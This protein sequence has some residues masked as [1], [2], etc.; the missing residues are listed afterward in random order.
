MA[1]QHFN[2][3]AS[4]GDDLHGVMA[5]HQLPK[6]ISDKIE[7]IGRLANQGF[8][9]AC[10]VVANDSFKCLPYEVTAGTLW[11][12][13]DMFKQIETLSNEI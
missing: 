8:S 10:A 9:I 2:E 3:S 1:T 13:E 7:A 6:D 12:L 11:A 4:T 5:R